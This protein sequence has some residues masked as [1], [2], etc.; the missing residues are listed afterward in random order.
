MIKNVRCTT[1]IF[2]SRLQYGIELFGHTTK[3]YMKELQVLQSKAIKVLYKKEFRTPT[4][5]LH[6]EFKILL[7]KDVQKLNTLKF[8]FKQRKGEAP[9]AFNNYFTE[10][11]AIHSHQTRQ[12]NNLH[13]TKPKTRFG[14]KSIKYYGPNVWNAL[15]LS[16]RQTDI[17]LK[18]FAR[19]LKKIILESY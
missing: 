18:C 5:E 9:E 7:V 8:V 10:N 11:N 3:G 16:A 2:F 19:N 13:S 15:N 12:A 6:K 14:K 4:K 17:T 1:P